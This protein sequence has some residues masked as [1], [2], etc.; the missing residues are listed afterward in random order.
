MKYFD[1][2]PYSKDSPSKFWGNILISLLLVVALIAVPFGKFYITVVCSA[3]F[4]IWFILG[5]ITFSSYDYWNVKK[6]I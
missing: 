4:L 1:K 5:N 6:E 3:L 2:V